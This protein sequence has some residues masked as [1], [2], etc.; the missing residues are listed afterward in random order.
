MAESSVAGYAR[1]VARAWKDAAFK[2]Q[3]LADP[4]TAL[5][6]MGVRV[7][8]CM[9]LKMVENTG[10]V[11]YGILPAPP[12]ETGLSDEALEEAAVKALNG[13]GGFHG[14]YAD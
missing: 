1:V 3:L 4:V 10:Q 6:A 7:P 5:A 11:T 8:E 14:S 9:M 12:A 2:R 13:L